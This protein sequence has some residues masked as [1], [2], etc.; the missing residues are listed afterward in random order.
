[1]Y[2]SILDLITV[3]QYSVLQIL[4]MKF[5]LLETLSHIFNCKQVFQTAKMFVLP[6]EKMKEFFNATQY[7]IPQAL[8]S[9]K[10]ENI[11]IEGNIAQVNHDK[12]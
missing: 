1:M 7:T 11:S 10:K 4:F 6:D 2:I 5:M 3:Y 9:P 8:V 12:Q